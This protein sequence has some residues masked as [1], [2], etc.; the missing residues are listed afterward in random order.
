VFGL[1][2]DGRL[3]C[4]SL[5]LI[6]ALM[7]FATLISVLGASQGRASDFDCSDFAHQAEG[8]GSR[9]R[10]PTVTALLGEHFFYKPFG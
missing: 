2:H 8:P 10:F 5:I 6:A 3:A 7:A 4:R 1:N 9:D